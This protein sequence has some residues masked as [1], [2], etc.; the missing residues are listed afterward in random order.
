MHQLSANTH[1]WMNNPHIEVQ[2][3]S[4]LHRVAYQL[5][6]LLLI[7]PQS[8]YHYN[9]QALAAVAHLGFRYQFVG[10]I[11]N[12]RTAELS[13]DPSEFFNIESDLPILDREPSPFARL[14]PSVNIS[15]N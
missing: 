10:K 13:C 15:G 5:Y 2:L 8:K 9:S 14:S 4:L 3:V 1:Y 11:E 12:P 7:A 6:L